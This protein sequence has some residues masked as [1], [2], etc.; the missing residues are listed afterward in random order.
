[1]AK[2][3]VVQHFLFGSLLSIKQAPPVNRL[4]SMPPPSMPHASFMKPHGASK[5][6]AE[7]VNEL[8]KLHNVDTSNT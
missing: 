6:P 1:M 5:P 3:P 7:T 8:D 4:T 2:F